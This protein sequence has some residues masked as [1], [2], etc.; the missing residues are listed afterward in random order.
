MRAHN[1][2]RKQRA[3]I[4]LRAGGCCE[5]CGARL[6]IG[7]GDA[8][9]ILPVEMGGESDITNGQWLCKGCHKG[10]TASDIRVIRKSDRQ[11]DNFTGAMPESR[12]PLPFGRN[13][14]F[15]KTFS[16]QVVPRQKAQS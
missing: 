10:K 7:E 1:F 14:A 2:S 9:H 15:K 3:E 8:D 12:N 11:R 6:K 5:E 13:S 16:G 4:A